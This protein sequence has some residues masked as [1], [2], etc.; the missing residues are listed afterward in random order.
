MRIHPLG[1]TGTA[2][3]LP[4]CAHVIYSRGVYGQI[5]WELLFTNLNTRA[6]YSCTV[7]SLCMHVAGS[8]LRMMRMSNVQFCWCAVFLF[9]SHLSHWS[10]RWFH[11]CSM[12]FHDA[13]SCPTSDICMSGTFSGKATRIRGPVSGASPRKEDRV[14]VSFSLRQT[15]RQPRPAFHAH[16]WLK[17]KLQHSAC[18][19]GQVQTIQLAASS[20]VEKNH[21]LCLRGKRCCSCK[22][23]RSDV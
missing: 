20:P 22:S 4:G 11:A 23:F 15:G 3:T 9:T 18:P 5:E 2:R 14:L 10:S 6:L 16:A 21:S 13:L 19:S 8:V 7:G 12:C 17:P 1:T